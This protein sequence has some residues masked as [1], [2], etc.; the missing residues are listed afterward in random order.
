M[1]E[2]RRSFLARAGVLAAPLLL[3]PSRTTWAAPTISVRDRGARG[4]GRTTDTR[5]IQAAIDDAGRAGG[6]GG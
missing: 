3:V 4:D 6:V 1:A 2:S 5:A